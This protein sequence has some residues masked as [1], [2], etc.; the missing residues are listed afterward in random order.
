[1]AYSLSPSAPA[2]NR[3]NGAPPERNALVCYCCFDRRENGMLRQHGFPT[4]GINKKEV[5]GAFVAP[6]RRIQDSSTTGPVLLRLDDEPVFV[7]QGHMDCVAI[8]TLFDSYGQTL[9]ND[10]E[11][12][13][14]KSHGAI[15]D[16]VMKATGGMEENTR[17]TVLEKM[18]VLQSVNH[19]FESA[20]ASGCRPVVYAYYSLSPMT[21]LDSVIDPATFPLMIF[22][23]GQGG[24]AGAERNKN[25][26]MT[27]LLDVRKSAPRSEDG[28]QLTQPINLASAIHNESL[29]A[30][31]HA[32]TGKWPMVDRSH[33]RQRDVDL[34]LRILR[35]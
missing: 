3:G 17:R 13:L 9:L 5:E 14:R 28:F 11:R 30:S 20:K 18:C 10:S 31:I 6:A 25:I 15:L 1:M 16:Q 32:K 21:D 8:K 22:D 2:A 7:V 26:R 33:I 24:F 12:E 23:P 4:F 34:A 29:Y 27:D 35:R 19:I